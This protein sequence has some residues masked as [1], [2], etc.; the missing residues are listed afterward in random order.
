M[1]AVF[2]VFWGIR[3]LDLTLCTLFHQKMLSSDTEAVEKLNNIF[4]HSPDC[5]PKEPFLF[6]S[7]TKNIC[8]CPDYC[9][10]KWRFEYL[11]IQE[12]YTWKKTT[13]VVGKKAFIFY[14]AVIFDTNK[15][16]KWHFYDSLTLHSQIYSEAPNKAVLYHYS[17]R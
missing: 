9:K 14:F 15:I 16:W 10:K 13:W 11:S 7:Q 3:Q 12:T 8:M 4:R 17:D 1:T 2:S 6:L 5:Q